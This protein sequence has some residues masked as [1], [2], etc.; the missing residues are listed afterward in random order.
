M[1]HILHQHQ[2]L[3]FHIIPRSRYE[4]RWCPKKVSDAPAAPAEDVVVVGQAVAGGLL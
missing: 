2:L 1:E 4:M 3:I